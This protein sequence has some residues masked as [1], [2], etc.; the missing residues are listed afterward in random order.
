MNN[1]NKDPKMKNFKIS[2]CDGYNQCQEYGHIAVD[3]TTHVKIALI[4][5]VFIITPESESAISSK[6]TPVIKEF[7][8][9]PPTTTVVVPA[10]TAITNAHSFS[11]LALLLTPLFP[12]SLVA[13][14]FFPLIVTYYVRHPF[15]SLLLTP[16]VIVGSGSHPFLLYCQHLLPL[17]LYRPPIFHYQSQTTHGGILV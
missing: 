13:P 16:T 14:F 9:V 5:G 1:R 10:V 17:L 2:T 3:C 12:P 8:V 7:S 4:N 6:I 15:S 11:S